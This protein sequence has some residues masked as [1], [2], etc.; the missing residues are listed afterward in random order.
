[1][2]QS[3]PIGNQNELEEFRKQWRQ[4]VQSRSKAQYENQLRQQPRSSRHS[5]GSGDVIPPSFLQT[6][7]L[8]CDPPAMDDADSTED[9]IKQEEEEE[10]K[11]SAMDHYIVA[12]DKERQGKIGPA[13]ESYRTAFKMDPDIDVAYKRHYHDNGAPPDAPPTTVDTSVNKPSDD[14][15]HIVPIG[16]EYVSSSRAD[17]LDDLV[18]QFQSES[19]DYIPAVDYKPVLIC[20][21]PSEIIV[22]V[23]QQLVLH[24]TAPIARF[25]LVCKNFFLLTR[26]QSLW[27]FAA[28]HAFR[29]PRMTLD[30]SRIKQASIVKLY[31]GQWN[32]MFIERPRV[33]YDGVYI[34]TCHYLRPGTSENTWNQPVHLVT[35]Y[36]YLRLFPDGTVLKYL[37]TDEPEHVVRLLTRDFSRRQ[38]FWGHFDV[39]EEGTVAVEM[40][41]PLRPRERFTM[42]LRIKST[43]RGRHN[44]LAWEEYSS[45]SQGRE[46]DPYQYDLR[47][48]KPYFFSVVRSYT[49]DYYH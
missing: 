46:D 8:E 5:T 6:C 9:D 17:P 41:D 14:F 25:A 42:S 43:H 29:T 13:L 37:S 3:S 7:S 18:R 22:Q 28:E 10:K 30:E 19:P 38:V 11:K 48:M 2:S 35:Y 47:M 24:S 27:R 26:S 15:R 4:E 1:M 39:D 40:K 23:L 16:S 12:V 44:K 31:S 21:L 45:V 36:R 32:R 34:A 49:L 33:R 20:K